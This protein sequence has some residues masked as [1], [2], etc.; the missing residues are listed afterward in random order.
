MSL[1]ELGKVQ[2]SE[3]GLKINQGKEVEQGKG[4]EEKRTK[5]TK[6]RDPSFSN[7]LTCER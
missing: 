3:L 6:A 2:M 4:E 7:S 1:D 5:L